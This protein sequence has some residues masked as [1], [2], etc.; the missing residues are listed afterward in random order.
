MIKTVIIDDESPICD[1]I[2][3]LLGAYAEIAVVGKFGNAFD[4]IA[5]IAEYRPPLVFLDIQMPGISG[6]EM[7]RKLKNLKNPPL[8]IMVTAHPEY[9]LDAFDTPAVGYIT[10]PVTEEKIAKVMEKIENLLPASKTAARLDVSRICVQVGGRI[11]PLAPEDIVLVGVKEKNVF[12]RTRKQEF[13]TAFSFQD[14]A[15]ILLERSPVRAKFVQVHRQFIV[16]LDNVLEVIPWMQG[17]YHLKMDDCKG[18]QVPVSRNKVRLIK[19]I[20]G[21]K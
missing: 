17:T 4:A 10:K 14:M 18:E 5:Y 16:N 13:S 19:E 3:Y 12:I 20:M 2:E 11:V 7:A 9:A 1:E 15:G 21:L 6:I 8:L